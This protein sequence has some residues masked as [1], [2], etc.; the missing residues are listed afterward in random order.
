LRD[1][2]QTS[3]IV[4]VPTKLRFVLDAVGDFI[5][6]RVARGINKEAIVEQLSKCYGVA[7]IT[8]AADLDDLIEELIE[9]GIL[10]REFL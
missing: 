5:W 1:D 6:R 7:P 8:A 3:V 10:V 2:E 9:A 4:R